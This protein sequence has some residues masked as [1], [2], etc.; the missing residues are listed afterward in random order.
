MKRLALFACPALLIALVVAYVRRPPAP[1][2]VPTVLPGM[3]DWD[4]PRLA[5]HLQDSGLEVRLVP[6]DIRGDASRS[7]FLTTTDKEWADLNPVLKVPEAINCWEGTV[8]CEKL[9]R[10]ERETQIEAWGDTCALVGPFL[11]FGDRAL[12]REVQ[13]LCTI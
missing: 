13:R 4:V 9:S 11:L 2:S 8:Y 7:A 6:T 12:L 3:E 5:Q 1:P 10:G